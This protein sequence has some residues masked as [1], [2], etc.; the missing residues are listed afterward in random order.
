MLLSDE[1][2]A[3]QIGLA[4]NNPRRRTNYNLHTDYQDPVQRFLNI[5]TDDSYIQ[6]HR[7]VQQDCW[8]GFIIIQGELCVLQFDH[9]GT[10]SHRHVLTTHGPAYGIELD[11]SQIHSIVSLSRQAVVFEYKQ[12]PYDPAHDK[13]FPSWSIDPEDQQARAYLNW[14]K[15]AQPGDNYQAAHTRS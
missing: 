3:A 13:S 1:L 2:I 11:S 10:V 5:V 7:H 9:H 8:E 15:Y 4:E 12:G 6:P 14:S